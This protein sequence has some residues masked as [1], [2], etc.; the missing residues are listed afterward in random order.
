MPFND[1][2]QWLPNIKQEKFLAIPLSIK[3]ALYGGG[4]GSG[5]SEVLLMYG[6]TNGWHEDPRFKQVFMRRTFPELRNEIVPRTRLIYP[7][8]GATFNKTDMTWTFPSGAAII[9]G[10][11]ENENDVHNYD[12]ME[13]NLFTPDEITSFTEWQYL[14]IAMTRVRTST[15]KLPAIIRAAGMPGN[16]GHVWVHKRFIKPDRNGGRII[17][18]RG[19]IKRIFIHATLADNPHIDPEYTNSLEALP[20]AERQ[21]KKFGSWDS[22]QG[23]VF[24]EFRDRRY[25]T[26]PENALHVIEEC[27]VPKW[28]PRIVAIDWGY[29][30]YTAIGYGAIS[31]N[32]NLYLYREQTFH[33]EKIEEWAPKVKHYLDIEN[34]NDIIICHSAAQ[35]RGQPHTI[36]EQVSDA[37]GKTLRLGEKDRIAG[38]MLVHEYLRWRLKSIPQREIEPYNAEKAEWLLRNKGIQIYQSYLNSFIIQQPEDNI[39]RLKI[40]R[41]CQYTIEAIK[42]CSYDKHN[43]EDVAEFDGDDHYDML[44]MLLHAADNFFQSATNEQKKLEEHQ[45]VINQYEVSQDMTAFYRNMRRLESK[46]R[47][48]PITRYHGTRNG[49]YARTH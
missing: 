43:P 34:P 3:E 23:Q 38:K 42:A 19:G 41:Q 16:I 29:V 17:V 32:H 26:E 47:I 24:D 8:F 7:K 11:C 10:H 18:G 25:P 12:S 40:F 4:A 46:D 6:I 49:Y 5:K 31:P 13:V 1:K 22:Y 48:L 36:L 27:E 30:A 35:H 9:L 45:S 33:K 20:E 14:Y 21:A 39:P 37:L 15:T 44:R 2:N 28:W